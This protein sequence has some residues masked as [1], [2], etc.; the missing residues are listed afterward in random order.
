MNIF[1]KSKDGGQES[2]V[3]GYWLIECKQL[4]SIVLLK[5]EGPSR[6]AFHTRFPFAIVV[7]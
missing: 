5:F 3:I 1:Y 4:F 6:K 7:N 2:T